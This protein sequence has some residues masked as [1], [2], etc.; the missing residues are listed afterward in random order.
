[1]KLFGFAAGAGVVLVCV[2]C[3]NASH[4]ALTNLDSNGDGT[5]VA[6]TAGGATDAGLADSTVVDGA[7]GDGASSTAMPDGGMAPSGE[8]GG[9]GAGA[10]SSLAPAT[11][12]GATVVLP[13]APAALGGVVRD[14]LYS[15]TSVVVYTMRTVTSN[16]IDNERFKIAGAQWEQVANYGSLTTFS[17]TLVQ[18]TGASALFKQ[19]CPTVNDTTVAYTASPSKLILYKADATGDIEEFTYTHE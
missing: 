8:G 3:S 12:V 2:A 16:V 7:T 14:G 13:P 4:P 15:I 6:A 19:T 11:T 9:T 5:S 1:M 17:G 18:G 10:C